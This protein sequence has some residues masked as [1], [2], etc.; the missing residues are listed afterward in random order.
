MHV[1]RRGDYARYLAEFVDQEEG[2]LPYAEQSFEAYTKAHHLASKTLP[3][4]HVGRLGLALNYSVFFYDLRKSPERAS[5][6]AKAA[7]DAAIKEL[8]DLT[9]ENY[10]ESVMILQLLRDNLT[11]WN[12]EIE[13]VEMDKSEGD[14]EGEGE[15]Q[16]VVVV[17]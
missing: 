13:N 1:L 16:A 9:E 12:S 6:I 15:K 2:D 17:E 11:L 4:T 10:R 5:H 3:A 8:D 14:G 7:F